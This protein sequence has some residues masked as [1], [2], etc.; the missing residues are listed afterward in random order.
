MFNNNKSTAI[1]AATH[2]SELVGNKLETSF[3]PRLRTQKICELV[4]N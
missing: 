2:T 1:K 4:S 3:Q